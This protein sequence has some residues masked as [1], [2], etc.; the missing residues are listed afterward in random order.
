MFSPVGRYEPRRP[1]GA[2]SSTIAGTRASAPISPP[3]PSI[4][5]PTTAAATS[6][7]NASGSDRPSPPL[8]PGRTSSAPATITS[9]ET[10]RFAHSRKPSNRLSVRSRSGTGSMPQPVS[11][12]IESAPFAGMTR[13]RF[14]GCV[15]SPARGT[16]VSKG[17]SACRRRRTT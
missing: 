3:M 1:S 14:D 16:P 9:S 11:S 15:L 8:D 4:R 12:L 17:Y 13:I 6:A 5:F 7:P 2:R 10:E